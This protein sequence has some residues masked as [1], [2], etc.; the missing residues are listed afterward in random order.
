[1][2]VLSGRRESLFTDT[3]VDGGEGG[4]GRAGKAGSAAAVVADGECG[5]LEE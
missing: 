3:H 5:G 1:M 2:N 4:E